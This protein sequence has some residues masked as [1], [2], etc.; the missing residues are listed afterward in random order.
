MI[1]FVL[2]LYLVNN[3]LAISFASK[4]HPI[5]AIATH[6]Q[7]TLLFLLYNHLTLLNKI[8]L[9]IFHLDV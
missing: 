2:V 6:L 5:D 8:N 4:V 7:N 1:R 9:L 3:Y